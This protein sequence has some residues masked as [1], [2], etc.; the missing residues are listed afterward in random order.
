MLGIFSEQWNGFTLQN[1]KE[2]I[3]EDKMKIIK[4][5]SLKNK[6]VFMKSE[7]RPKTY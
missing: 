6:N 5:Q 3:L 1:T 7:I 4:M 2:S